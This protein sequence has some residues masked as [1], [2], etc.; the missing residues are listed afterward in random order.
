RKVDLGNDCS[1]L[2]ANFVQDYDPGAEKK[3]QYRPQKYPFKDPIEHVSN[4]SGS[5]PAGP[6]VGRASTSM[7]PY[8]SEICPEQ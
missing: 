7:Q 5:L 3:P 6:L 4:L 8:S 2:C 1:D